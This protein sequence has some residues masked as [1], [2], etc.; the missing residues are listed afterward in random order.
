[1]YISTEVCRYTFLMFVFVTKCP[2]A[3]G[4][5]CLT[6]FVSP[7]GISFGVAITCV[8]VSDCVF[9]YVFVL[10][11]CLIHVLVRVVEFGL[12]IR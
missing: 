3:M 12:L 6:S 1:M 11:Y 4:A 8:F 9:V 10:V 7:K 2:P 5:L